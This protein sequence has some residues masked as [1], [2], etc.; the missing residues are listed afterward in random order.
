MAFSKSSY[1]AGVGTVFAAITLGFAGGAM[2]TG[3][4]IQAPNRV[5]RVASSAALPM[6]NE[7]P[8]DVAKAAP[9]EPSAA[10]APAAPAPAA[11]DSRPVVQQPPPA[12]SPVTAKSEDAPTANVQQPAPAPSARPKGE[13]AAAPKAQQPAHPAI[14]KREDAASAKRE[15]DAATAK[16]ERASVR[17]GSKTDSYRQRTDERKFIERKRRQEIED[18]ANA[19]RQMRRD[20]VIDRVLARDEPHRVI[21]RDEP[22][23]FGFFGN[24]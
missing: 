7:Q 3:S 17:S 16:N 9:P 10:A 24:D 23:R 13:D 4:A 18:A 1:F 11:D 15:E 8:A 2:L 14:A 5:E 12:S 21:V 20:G 6:S 22:P 19:V